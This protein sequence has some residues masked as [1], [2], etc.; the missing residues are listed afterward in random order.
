[1]ANREFLIS[2]LSSVGHRLLEAVDGAEALELARLEHPDLVIADILMPTMDGYEFVRRLRADHSLSQIP[3]LFWTAHYHEEEA[4]KLARDCGVVGVLTKP[5]EPLVVLETVG[6]VLAGQSF[7]AQPPP[8]AASDFDHG[9]LRLVSDKLSEKADELRRANERLTAL[10]E[11]SLQL[12]SERD[13]GRLLQTFA[14]VAR[15]L[16]GARFSIVGVLG[17]KHAP[18]RHCFTSG[19]DA[20]AIAR[21][22]LPRADQGTLSNLA[23]YEKSLRGENP[24]G[25]PV[26]AGFGPQF[27]PIHSWLGITIRSLSKTYGWILLIDK[28][29]AGAF[30][31]EDER[32]GDMLSAQVGRIY[33]NGSL[34]AEGVRQ[35]RDLSQEVAERRRAEQRFRSL[36]ESTPDPL[37]IVDGL[38]VIA[39]A[40]ERTEKVFGYPRN[41]L[42]GRPVEILFPERLRQNSIASRQP[43]LIDPKLSPL[44]EA[45]ELVG[46]RKNGSEIP[47][48]IN[49]SPLQTDEGILV[50]IVIRNISA[51]KQGEEALQR[52]QKRL[53]H[54]ISS[55]PAVIYSFDVADHR[56][57]GISWVS[58]TVKE[59]LGYTP[60]EVR[61]ENWWF[62]NIH[63]EEVNRVRESIQRALFNQE[64]NADEF[65]FRH[66]D[67]S[68]RWVRSEMRLL[69]DGEGRP[70]EVVGSWSDI[71][72][73]KH[74]ELQILQAQKMEAVGKLA[75]GIAHDFNNLLTVINGYCE[76]LLAGVQAPEG[77]R[78]ILEEVRNAGERA[79]ALTR[80]LLAFS[81]KAVLAPVVLDLNALVRNLQ[82]ML[83]RLI[84]EDIE[85][86]VALS[87]ALWKTKVDP[88][89]MDQIIMNLVVNA[90][91]AMPRGGKLTIT[92]ANVALDRTYSDQHAETPP[93][94]YVQLS[95][96]DS[97]HGM[98]AATQ[99]R[100]FEPFF[101][102]KGPD[103]GTGLGLSVVHG[104]VQQSG[105]R[106]EVYSELG[107]GTTFKIYL[108]S[109]GDE[110]PASKSA[111]LKT[112][113]RGTETILLVEDEAGVR[114]LTRHI[115]ERQGYTVLEAKCG[116]EA[117]E[118]SQ[119][120]PGIIQLM[121]TDTVMPRLSG[122][123]VAQKLAAERPEMKVLYLSGYTDEA[124]VHHGIIDP[125]TPFLQKPFTVEALAGKVRDLLD[126]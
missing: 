26:A 68:Y 55:N 112:Q 50:T 67:G 32:L 78:E 118:I 11:L 80:Q 51:R 109:V 75:G 3:V 38:G 30:R 58:N 6:A 82:K 97:G 60:D 41:E 72:Q 110:A 8:P 108:P 91:D 54:I 56:I 9:H 34:Y 27:P 28:L 62:G 122:L 52:I 92:T 94:D 20:A 123:Q 86:K 66:R 44:G 120:F 57:Q 81:R 95:V 84:G 16:A 93:G 4:N 125:D 33:E 101:T 43:Y 5:T 71:T 10:M 116:D 61:G 117:I 100:I 102:T 106:V 83:S 104:I 74:L 115:L 14:H 15:E 29:G 46:R 1:M 103:M 105:G 19:M 21:L 73:R 70:V 13:V 119:K 37:V 121:V 90:R 48:E 76:I 59:I 12:G 18:I 124:I 2:L 45:L 22:G 98:D 7:T 89:Q 23:D 42:I 85:L 77:T 126:G 36:L 40:N 49:L 31:E 35:T 47:V 113:K 39:I 114:V 88:G 69:R 25:D 64:H 24:G 53:E 65:R 63:P 17:G 79:A 99:T 87:P 96:S 111:V 107:V